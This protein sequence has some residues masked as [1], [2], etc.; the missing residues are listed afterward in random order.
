MCFVH[1]KASTFPNRFFDVEGEVA[2]GW[3]WTQQSPKNTIWPSQN[4][5]VS[6]PMVGVNL[7]AVCR[8]RNMSDQEKYVPLS[9]RIHQ[10][11]IHDN[12]VPRYSGLATVKPSRVILIG[13]W[14]IFF[15]L[16]LGS[17]LS[18]LAAILQPL[19]VVTIATSI[20]GACPL[21][22]SLVILFSQTRR[23]LRSQACSL[24]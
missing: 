14:L 16:A 7:N 2:Q 8:N 17:F 3:C 6:R 15:P 5:C 24:G 20:L 18:V 10:D 4:R 23:F 22:L 19:S 11:V 1:S 12:F 21:G 13:V 9:E